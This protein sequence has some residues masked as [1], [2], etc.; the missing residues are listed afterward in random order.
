VV[1]HLGQMTRLDRAL[2]GTWNDRSG[3]LECHAAG[4]RST[5]PLSAAR[6][7]DGGCHERSPAA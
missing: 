7:S 3:V 2:P 4:I 6:D 5:V 1:Q